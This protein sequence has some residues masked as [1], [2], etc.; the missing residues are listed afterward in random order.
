MARSLIV[1]L[2]LLGCDAQVGQDYYGEPLIS[3]G[4]TVQSSMTR[5]PPP[6]EVVLVWTVADDDGTLQPMG[7]SVPVTGQFPAQ[8]N[9]NVYH[10]PP[11]AAL[12]S[13]EADGSVRLALGFF[14]VLVDGAAERLGEIRVEDV[15]G[16]SRE[17]FLA[18]FETGVPLGSQA[19]TKYGGAY[20]AGYTLFKAAW[21]EGDLQAFD[22]CLTAQAEQEADRLTCTSDCMAT[23]DESQGSERDA[24]VQACETEFPLDDCFIEPELSLAPAGLKLELSL[25]DEF[26]ADEL[27]PLLELSPHDPFEP[28]AD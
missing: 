5:T 6:A 1:V 15:L 2:F 24:C 26:T 12:A 9:L 27:A 20:P 21:N 7:M 25:T 10:P 23:F 3:I 22:E 11:A 19:A 18:Y 13:L 8:F 16:V 17:S 28:L 4:G 14:F